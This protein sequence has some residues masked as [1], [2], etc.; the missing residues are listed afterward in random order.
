VIGEY[1]IISARAD[2]EETSM[3]QPGLD[4]R[5]RDKDGEISRKKSNTLVRSLRR[6][7]GNDFAKGYPPDA[8][9][10]SVLKKEKVNS[11]HDLLKRKR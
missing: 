7:Y 1:P 5:H 3:K 6:E 8:T 11:L 10:G 4:K 2:D 9:L